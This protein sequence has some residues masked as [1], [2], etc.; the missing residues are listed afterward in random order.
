ML[1]HEPVA[2][3]PVGS[4][5]QHG[6][7]LPLGTD[8]FVTMAVMQAALA[9]L[10]KATCL[11]LPA[12]AVGKSN[13]HLSFLGT[14]T[15]SGTTLATVVGELARSL[16]RHGLARL[17][18]VSGHGGNLP[19]L[20]ALSRDLRIDQR[21]LVFV[22]SAMA[23][24]SLSA[25]GIARGDFHGGDSETSMIMAL[26]PELVRLHELPSHNPPVLSWT[27]WERAGSAGL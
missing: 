10:P 8:T 16:S 21:L 2:I 3:L 22:T 14:L 5:E 7:H 19:V 11:V 20:E 27:G 15:L 4:T 25:H 17:V 9:R 18:L 24:V 12:L 1:G 6:P 26:R 23:G 13:E